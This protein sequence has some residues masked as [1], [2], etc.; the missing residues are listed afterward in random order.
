MT[1]PIQQ[2]GGQMS[3]PPKYVPI[4]TNRWITGLWT[5]RSPL[6]DAATPY[7][8]EKFYSGTRFESLYGGS[9]CE[10]SNR[11]T[12]QRRPGHTVY[13]SATFPAI[14]AFYEFRTFTSDSENIYV[15]ADTASNIYNATG[16]STQQVIFPKSAGSGQ[17]YMQSVGNS[18]Y[19]GDGVDLLQWDWFQAWTALT[20]Y[21]TGTVILDPDNNLQVMQGYGIK[22]TSTSVFSNV[23]TVTCAD[24]AGL[25]PGDQISFR[26]MNVQTWLNNNTYTVTNFALS[27]VI[28]AS[29][30]HP[31]YLTTTEGSA[32]P[33]VITNANE[34]RS[35]VTAP[36]WN[37]TTGGL[38]IEDSI[39]GNIW[40]CHGPSVQNWGIVGPTNAPQVANTPVSL[41]NAWAANTYYWPS[42][43]VVDSA[44][45][46]Q[47]LTT[48][49]TTGGGTPSWTTSTTNDGSAVW[50]YQNSE[51]RVPSTVYAVGAS[52]AVTYYITT[53]V[54]N[55]IPPPSKIVETQGPYS[56]FFTCTTPGTSSSAATHSIL[57]NSGFVQ[58]GTVTWFN[59][60]NVT[61]RAAGTT[62]ESNIGDSILVSNLSTVIDSNFN[63]EQVSIG[64][65]SGGTAPSWMAQGDYTVDGT[66]PSQILWLNTGSAAAANT[67]GWGYAYAFKNSV[68]S[69]V[70]TASPM[71]AAILRK[72]ENYI[73]VSGA[74][75]SD[76]QVDTIEIYRTVQGN[77]STSTTPLTTGGTLYWLADIP[78]PA[79]G[80]SW[81]YLDTSPDPPSPTSTLN[82]LIE[83]DTT[84]TN[85][86]PPAGLSIPTYHLQR[87]WGAV[88]N[89]VYCSGGPDILNGNP[90]ECFSPADNFV[91]PSQVT[92]L[93]PNGS[94][95][96]YVFTVSDTYVIAGTTIASFYA[97][98][99]L[100]NIGLASYN[101]LDIDGTVLYMMSNDRHVLALD[102]S[103]GI[104]EVGFPIGDQFDNNY[105]PASAYIA[106]HVGGSQDTALY[107]ADG[108]TGWYRMDPTPAPETGTT[109]SPFA[110]ITGGVQAVQSVEVTPGTKK[111]L[112]GPT[113]SGP[114]L[115][116][117]LNTF[118]D[119]GS[120]YTWN[121]I[122]GSIV[123]AQPGELAEISFFN[124]QCSA[125][126]SHPSI[127][128]L[129]DEISGTFESLPTS[130]NASVLPPSSSLYE[131][132]FYLTQGGLPALCRHLQ[133]QISFPAE[134]VKNELLT[135][136][137]FGRHF[138]ERG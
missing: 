5:Q 76:P 81:S 105:N 63:N 128:V 116:R 30:N 94:S 83:A 69:N 101:A 21:Q 103:S 12:L 22:V 75:S 53:L 26:D 49:G 60:G 51:T 74:G 126:G 113:T 73:T 48:P 44:N 136:T 23:L 2:A 11:L 138:T 127:S 15:M 28:L 59:S 137:I 112:L 114:I 6:R 91:F 122:I 77:A 4:F 130:V 65:L 118:T 124:T 86:P 119:N 54:K 62:T 29:A 3:K 58:D 93:W 70:S 88:D 17:G 64:G 134:A 79:N 35:Y 34:G 55:P 102:P 129:L 36:T 80:G 50:T 31:D 99:L 98:P 104:S 95:G 40:Q 92:R 45:N 46:L 135:Y 115:E 32:T 106:W 25:I 110:T 82:E 131:D 52:I 16:P 37:E 96:L 108:A 133:L 67:G 41:T 97:V 27:N 56:C 89:T 24:V 85:T 90:N 109:W 120:T 8:Y 33:V 111:L 123:L 7:L 39:R 20:L 61:T 71:T 13:N 19:M 100:A 18:L 117:S 84:G 72:A 9:N 42:Q 68:T 125:A 107:V 132:W 47:L 38:T 10:L 14:D 78:A 1:S 87:I 57:W 66:T 121:A 43:T